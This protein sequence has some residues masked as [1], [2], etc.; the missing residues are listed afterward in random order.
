MN[1]FA[2]IIKLFTR[3]TRLED[4]ARQPL[5]LNPQKLD[6]TNFELRVQA[7]VCQFCDSMEMCQPNE[8]YGLFKIVNGH[9]VRALRPP[10]GLTILTVV[11]VKCLVMCSRCWAS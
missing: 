4:F 6:S 3:P 7:Q 9:R 10:N 2:R 5:L 1:I 8:Y 11:D